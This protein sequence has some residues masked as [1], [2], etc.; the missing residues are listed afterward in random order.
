VAGTLFGAFLNQ[1][2][3]CC[4]LTRLIVHADVYDAVV[5]RFV[6][7]ARAIPVGLP[8]DEAT[9]LGPL[10][11]PEHLKTVMDYVAAGRAEGATLLCG[12]HVLN[13]G[14]LAAGSF[15]EPTVFADV[16]PSMRI[17]REEIF[18]PVV[19][20]A[21]A[22]STAELVQLA[23]DTCYGLA[24][25]IWTT[26]LK[27]AHTL[28]RQVRAGTVWFNLHNFVFPSAPYGGYGASGIGR[29]LGKQGML[30]L[31]R[32]KNVMVSLFPGGFKW[33]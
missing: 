30:A 21:K 18:G 29:E 15:M 17:W 19:V 33:Y 31:T 22:A 6:A 13:Q 9:R 1:G 14:A 23:N 5:S 26:N 8:R 16:T 2:E 27:S 11:H 28:A 4:A 12:G 25:S 7:G 20:I 24:A 32:T 3:C 10:V